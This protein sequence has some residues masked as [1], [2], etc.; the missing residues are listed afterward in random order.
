MSLSAIVNRLGVRLLGSQSLVDA[1]YLALGEGPGEGNVIWALEA[2]Y[3]EGRLE[4][5]SPEL[6]RQV[7]AGS[8]TR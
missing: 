6:W 5:T 1:V 2:L 7:V 3:E 8:V 4:M